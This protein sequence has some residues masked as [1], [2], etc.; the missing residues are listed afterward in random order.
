M[1]NVSTMKSKCIHCVSFFFFAGYHS[2]EIINIYY[3]GKYECN[4]VTSSKYD[5]F[6][7]LYSHT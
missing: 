3:L 2:K 6:Q 1:D 4:I 5:Y 7:R